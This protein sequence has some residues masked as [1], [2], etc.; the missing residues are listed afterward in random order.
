MATVTELLGNLNQWSQWDTEINVWFWDDA[1]PGSVLLFFRQLAADW[2]NDVLQPPEGWVLYHP[3]VP[4]GAELVAIYRHDNPPVGEV[5][6]GLNGV[7][8]GGGVFGARILLTDADELV[9]FSAAYAG[10]I[11]EHDVFTFPGNASE[12][13]QAIVLAEIERG[14]PT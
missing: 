4:V 14:I 7:H 11:N 1:E 13:A 6:F 5:I 10:T 2:D 3:P 12:D 9:G 8:S